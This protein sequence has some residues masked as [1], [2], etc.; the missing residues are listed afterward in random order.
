MQRIGATTL[1]IA[2]LV[3]CLWVALPASAGSVLASNETA[4]SEGDRKTNVPSPLNVTN[5]H[6]YHPAVPTPIP[7][8]GEKSVGTASK[9]K[10][11]H[12]TEV[13]AGSPRSEGDEPGVGTGLL[14]S[15]NNNRLKPASR[16]KFEGKRSVHKLS[17]TAHNGS[18]S[19]TP[20]GTQV[21]P[22][23]TS[24]RVDP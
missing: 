20:P 11:A 7:I 21:A 13:E 4:A 14:S 16:V 9:R 24:V 1:G 19:N 6:G 8:P 15:K 23:Q 10:A 3:L 22:S 17:P 2:T 12:K 5:L 18:N